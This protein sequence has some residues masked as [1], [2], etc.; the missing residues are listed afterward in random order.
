MQP[1]RGRG[2]HRVPPQGGTHG[3]IDYSEL[4]RLGISPQD[5][6]DFSVS[7]NP[8]GP[9]PGI[10]EA[11]ARAP[12]D[13]Y[14]DS[15]STDLREELAK[16]LAISPERLFI[17]SG[18]TEI[19][20][21]L[22]IACFAPQERVIIPEPTYGDY[23][24]ACHLAGVRTI[25]ASML[26]E[27]GFRTNVP[28]L[29]GLVREYVPEGL[30]LCNPN[31]PTGQYLPEQDVRTI[32]YEAGRGLVVLDEAYI[33]LTAG[34]WDSTGL[35][36]MGN[37]VSVRSMTKDYAL[38]GLRLGY[39]IAPEAVISALRSVRPP[40]NVSSVAQAAGLFALGADAYLEECGRRLREARGFLM[41][42]LA[43]LGLAPLPSRAN[44][45]LVRVGDA[46]GFRSALLTRGIIVRDCT[47]F[48]LPDYIRL[49]PRTIPDCARLLDAIR[50]AL[51]T[52][53]GEH[54][55]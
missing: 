54:A 11:I 15:E 27:A 48:G 6:T 29:V 9:P 10:A 30:F 53:G 24:V 22:A 33:G 13:R 31:N 17:G 34:A 55:P 47:S 26:G 39:A 2:I 37:L 44:F 51:R 21:L 46:T 4:K 7:I 18:S 43:G 16:R 19:I 14:P 32:A 5:V 42:G 20:R 49:A 45:F 23:E 36:D 1:R 40:W 41:E 12:L 38:A 25:K 8:F 28:R 3:G 35:I 52:R 50:E